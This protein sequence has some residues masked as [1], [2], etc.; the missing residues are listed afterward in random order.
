MVG[1]CPFGPALLAPE[2][3]PAGSAHSFFGFFRLAGFLKNIK[4]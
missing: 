3:A 4:S 2:G 1:L